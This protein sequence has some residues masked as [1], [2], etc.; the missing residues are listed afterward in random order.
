[1]ELDKDFIKMKKD[2]DSILF[3]TTKKLKEIGVTR[4]SLKQYMSDLRNFTEPEWNEMTKIRRE[5]RKFK[6]GMWDALGIDIA[7]KKK[8]LK[9]KKET[10]KKKVAKRERKSKLAIKKTESKQDVRSTR[11]RRRLIGAKKR[12]TRM[13]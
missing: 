10:K 8:K 1:M 3:E 6:K 12:W 4:K 9:E 7:K 2:F 5:A 11:R 13:D